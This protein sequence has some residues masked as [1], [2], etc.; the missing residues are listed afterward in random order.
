MDNFARGAY[1]RAGVRAGV[2]AAPKAALCLYRLRW[3]K[4]LWYPR[5]M[6]NEYD[7][8]IRGWQFTAQP[9][10]REVILERR[11]KELETVVARLEREI[12]YKQLWDN[13]TV[14]PRKGSIGNIAGTIGGVLPASPHKAD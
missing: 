10:S 12:R 8:D 2:R 5:F 14:E 6:N 3:W 4:A 13:E 7:D 11:V 9:T 1:A